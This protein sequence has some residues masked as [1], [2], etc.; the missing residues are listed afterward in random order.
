M[1]LLDEKMEQTNDTLIKDSLLYL[2]ENLQEEN[3]P[4][5]IVKGLIENIR[6][7]KNLEWIAYLLLQYYQY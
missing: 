6:K 7:D 5:A 2:R 4:S 3:L 1:I